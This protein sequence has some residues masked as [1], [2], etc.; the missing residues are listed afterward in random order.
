M[1]FVRIVL[2]RHHGVDRFGK[3]PHYVY[4]EP[5]PISI[6]ST[7]RVRQKCVGV[8]QKHTVFLG[9]SEKNHVLW[10]YLRYA[11]NASA[12][13]VETRASCFKD[14]DAKC[15]CEGGIEEY[16]TLNENLENVREFMTTVTQEFGLHTERTS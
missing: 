13:D 1:C 16:G 5:G 12:N 4:I 11:S 15:L 2:P 7:I 3:G 8:Y 10:Q 6:F 14:S 9:S